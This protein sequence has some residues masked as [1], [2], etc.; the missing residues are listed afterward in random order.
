MPGKFYVAAAAH[1]LNKEGRPLVMKRSPKHDFEGG[2]WETVSGRLEQHIKD[3][4]SELQREIAEELGDDFQCEIIAPIGTY[5]F[6][7]GN[8][9]SKEHVGMDYVC[10]YISGKIRLSKEHTEYKWIDPEEFESY[11]ASESLKSKIELLSKIKD[12]YLKNT[13]V[14]KSCK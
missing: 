10:K 1:I 2:Y 11:Q 5:N 13:A 4:K 3:V 12:W 7:R 6:Y 9:K 8:N 14:F